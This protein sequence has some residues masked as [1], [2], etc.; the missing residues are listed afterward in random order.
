MLYQLG[1]QQDLFGE[2]WVLIGAW[3]PA[4]KSKVV[5]AFQ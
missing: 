3:S 4:L 1:V 2:H 5:P